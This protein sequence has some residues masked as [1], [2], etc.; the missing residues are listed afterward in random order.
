MSIPPEGSDIAAPVRILHTKL[1][2]PRTHPDI[3]QRTW[4]DQKLEEGLKSQLMILS[5]PAGSGKTTLLSRWITHIG[6]PAAWLSLDER[7]NDF[8]R[9]WS[10]LI[11]ALQTLQAETGRRALQMLQTPQP[12]PT[13]ALLTELLNDLSTLED[14][15][16]LVLDDY[17]TIENSSIHDGLCYVL[18]NMP[19]Q[20]H[21]T[22]AGRS[23][24]PLPLP[25]L[26]G[27]RNLFE[28]QSADLRFTQEETA[29]FLNRVMKLGLSGEHIVAIQ[30][31]TEGWAAGIQLAAMALE[32]IRK[33]ASPTR[34]GQ[35]DELKAFLA[36][37]SGSHHFVFDYL[38]QEVVDH[39]PEQVQTFL[40]QTA[41]LDRLCGPLCSALN[42]DGQQDETSSQAILEQL[43]AANLFIVPL[44]PHRRWYRYHHLFASF[45]QARLQKAYPPQKIAELHRLACSWLEANGYLYEA[46]PH[47][48]A[49]QDFEHAV[50]L[51]NRVSEEM[52]KTS[53]LTTLKTWLAGIP[54]ELISQSIDLSMRCA[55]S[56]LATGEMEKAEPHLS[57]VEKLLGV[58]A[59][60]SEAGMALPF[61]QRAILAE[62]SSIRA[63]LHFNQLDLPAVLD[64]CRQ[65]RAY[66]ATLEKGQA[67][68]RRTDVLG[69]LAFNQAIASEYSGDTLA[70]EEAF[71]EANRLNRHNPHLL[72]MGSGHLAG[73]HILKGQ[74][75]K[76]EAFY[77][78]AMRSA[79]SGGIPSPLSAIAS[80]GLG[81]LLCE[82]NRLDQALN[83][84]QRG[85]ELGRQWNQWESLLSGYTGLARLHWARGE[86]EVAFAKLDELMKRSEELDVLWM[87]PPVQAYHALL[88]ARS[89]DLHSAIA[90][91]ESCPV[92]HSSAIH[93]MLE[94]DALTLARIHIIQNRLPEAA[95][96]ANG[97]AA[98]A[99][100]GGRLGRWTEAILL[101]GLALYLQGKMPQALPLLEKAL[102]RALAEDYRRVFL[103]EGPPMADFLHQ[104]QIT[105][106]DSSPGWESGL[107]QFIDEL[108]SLFEKP[109]D[110]DK[111]S[112]KLTRARPEPLDFTYEPLSERE[113]E[114]MKLIAT[115]LTNQEISDQLFISLNTVKTHVKNIYQRLEVTNRAQ[116]IARARQLGLI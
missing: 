84:L 64:L 31:M 26:R 55:W 58:K 67:S 51:I 37:F 76:A 77:L 50:A 6:R 4:L 109:A 79:Q 15:F 104:A 116:A 69:V 17:H 14:D 101:N 3:V 41:I 94:P 83:H 48:L 9:F 36:A 49:S 92:S 97:T 66:I 93:F 88:S 47:A 75:H 87:T 23:R 78:E 103:D 98:S 43:E 54:Q 19:P 102:Q 86:H 106:P 68:E 95:K 111:P 63:T 12:P 72:S 18:E 39:Q 114:V 42:P 21:L 108:L 16:V 24:P 44:D 82:W 57:D 10:Y 1:F 90:W 62:I 34:P 81:N 110:Q 2:I 28:L 73:I 61:E 35:P 112:P 11:A 5:A 25:L 65:G 107:N 29:T 7:D 60:G 113:Q 56:K 100:S 8:T 80:T 71:Q 91:A 53:Q 27:R 32:A 33:E 40:L 52:F 115:G 22:I 20:M 85:I 45:L 70:A 13:E 96:L 99:Q 74:L 105:G 59:D 89:G 38:A 46:I 30:E